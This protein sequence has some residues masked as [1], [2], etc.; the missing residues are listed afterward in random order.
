MKEDLLQA[1]IE[2]MSHQWQHERSETQMTLGKLINR[3]GELPP[4]TSVNLSNPHSYRGYYSDLSF[5]SGSTTAGEALTMVRNCMGQV[6]KGYKG[7][8]FPMH[9]NSPVW[10]ASYGCCGPKI[11]AINDD[12]TLVLGEDE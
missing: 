7:G 10:Q 11:M 2:G 1:A 6:F 12:G 8:D 3:L 9:A 5:E 4:E